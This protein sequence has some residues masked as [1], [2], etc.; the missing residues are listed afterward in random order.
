MEIVGEPAEIGAN[1]A[2]G[3]AAAEDRPLF[4][5]L[6]GRD[7]AADGNVRTDRALAGLRVVSG[8]QNRARLPALQLDLGSAFSF[9]FFSSYSPIYP[10][11]ALYLSSD[12][13]YSLCIG[14]IVCIFVT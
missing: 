6:G 7:R 8:G 2:S 9:T 14:F 3:P 13:I 5:V 4:S 11:F 10:Y 12:F 1:A